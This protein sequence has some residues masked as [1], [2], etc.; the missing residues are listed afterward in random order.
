MA[1]LVFKKR[2]LGPWAFLRNY[3]DCWARLHILGR[4]LF[5]CLFVCSIV[6]VCVFS[7]VSC[8]SR[9]KV[10]PKGKRPTSGFPPPGPPPNPRTA[11]ARAA[12]TATARR[13]AGP[14]RRRARR[15]RSCCWRR[16][17]VP[18]STR[19]GKRR[20]QTPSVLFGCF[21]NKIDGHMG[22]SLC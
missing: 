9:C 1:K 8:S 3:V 21:G 2:T 19:H 22:E 5:V 4:Q 7:R 18:T 11:P 6:C 20:P 12:G 10:Q 16:R 17:P 15:W 14:C 13:C